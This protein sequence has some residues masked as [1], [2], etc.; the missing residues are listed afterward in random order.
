MVA[1]VVYPL[2]NKNPVNER[3]QAWNK[4]ERAASQKF[5]ARATPVNMQRLSPMQAGRRHGLSF[6]QTAPQGKASPVVMQGTIT[7]PFLCV[8]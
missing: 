3:R 1:Y 4:T 6:C 8:V 5:L 2:Q 7:N